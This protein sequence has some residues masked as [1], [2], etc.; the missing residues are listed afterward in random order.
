MNIKIKKI[1][2]DA[3]IPTKG[4]PDAAGY[5]MYAHSYTDADAPHDIDELIIFPHETKKIGTGV[6]MEI[7][8]GV[9]GLLFAR[10][11]IATKQGLRPANCV[12]VIDP[13]FRG[14]I[15]VAMHNDTDNTQVISAGSRIAQMV[16]VPYIDAYFSEVNDLSDTIRGEGGFG[17]TGMN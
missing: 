3:V 6:S 8:Q 17:H 14:E 15:A 5:D 7:P 10:S 13:D 1:Y 9:V 4:S 16:F 2:E 11:G 12:G